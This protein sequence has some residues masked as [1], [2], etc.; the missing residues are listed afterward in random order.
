M[1]AF[2]LI[3]LASFFL[4]M[5]A[6]K[7]GGSSFSILYIIVAFWVFLTCI[8]IIGTIGL[9]SWE[10]EGVLWLYINLLLFSLAYFI[11]SK[12]YVKVY[13]G[14]DLQDFRILKLTRMSDA[15]F[16]GL[17]IMAFVQWIYQVY[18]F[19]FNLLSFT[20]LAS[21]A[22]MNNSLAVERYSGTASLNIVVQI[23]SIALYAAPVCG[24]FSYP[25]AGGFKRKAI[26]VL[27]LCPV[28]LV[29][30]TQN[31][32]ATFIGGLL[33]FISG[34]VIGFYCK[35]HEWLSFS[36]K[37]I[38]I[39]LLG[40]C[41]FIIFMLISMMLRIGELSI[42]TLAVVLQKLV[43]YAFGNIQSF[44][45][46]FA[47]YS[48]YENTT[49][50]AMTFLGISD[51]LGL[52]TR[53]QGVYTSLTGTASNVYTA[54]R[55]IITDFGYIGGTIY[56]MLQ[57]LILGLAV[58]T[59]KHSIKPSISIFFAVSVIFFILFGLFVSPWSYR[60]FILTMVVFFLYLSLAFSRKNVL[61]QH[62]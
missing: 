14:D 26:S 46:W 59:V 36:I 30:L 9:F 44:D 42:Y 47:N 16:I 60:S 33:F 4:L 61:I 48:A 31:T 18:S 53:V 62:K 50:G 27:S 12:Y 10:Y 51:M 5:L 20:S 8:S 22:E 41:A 23:L 54:M 43:V 11:G 1:L 15:F 6:R 40:F 24:G 2:L 32:K 39:L 25:F 17:I 7:L 57:G 28:V 45:I 37:K 3:I 56:L 35:N 21:L 29:T 55:G 13:N 34:I 38:I 58:N 52:A 19:G 49:Y